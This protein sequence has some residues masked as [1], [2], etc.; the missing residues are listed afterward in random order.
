MCARILFIDYPSLRLVSD[1]LAYFGSRITWL[2]V[3]GMYESCKESCSH[4]HLSNV[5][6]LVGALMP[7]WIFLG[8]AVCSTSHVICSMGLM[9]CFLLMGNLPLCVATCNAFFFRVLQASLSQSQREAVDVPLTTMQVGILICSVFILK[10][11]GDAAPAEPGGVEQQ[12]Q[13][14]E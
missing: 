4:K 3:S 13:Q 12:H 5:A 8:P 11:S 14:E 1:D 10:W 9:A 6:F 7:G 2:I